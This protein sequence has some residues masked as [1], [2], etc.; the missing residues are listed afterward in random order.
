MILQA[1]K[2]QYEALAARGKIKEPGWSPEKVSYA[3][4]LRLDG[5]VINV[6][7]LMQPSEKSKKEAPIKILVPERVTRSSGVKANFLCDS[8]AYIFGWGAKGDPARALICFEACKKLHCDVLAGAESDAAR[9]VVNYFT[10]WAPQ[11]A[12]THPELHPY[13]ENLT[14]A[15][16]VF[17]FDG[18]YAHEDKAVRAAWREY[19]SNN[20]GKTMMRCL[21]TG[22]VAP[23]AILHSK[24]KGVQGAQSS[25]GALVSFNERAYESY[26]R[27]KGQ[28]LNAPV[29]EYAMFAYISALN[30]MLADYE[31][32]RRIGDMTV[33]HWGEKADPVMQDIYCKF[34][35]PQGED[36]DADIQIKDIMSRI[37]AGRHIEGVDIRKKFYV[38]G[39]APNAARLSVRLFWQGE[40]GY[41]LNNLCKHYNDIEIVKAP[42]EREY[43]SVSNLLYETVNQKSRDKAAAPQMAGDVFRAVLDGK[44]YPYT[45]YHATLRRLKAD[46]KVTRGRVAIIKAY[47]IRKNTLS[48]GE[49]L[50]VSLDKDNRNRGYLLGRLFASLES[51]QQA[52]NPGINATIKDRYFNAACATPQTAF[53]H[54][55]KLSSFHIKKLQREKIGLAINLEKEK[56]EILD[57]F[58]VKNTIF[59][60]RLSLEDQGMFIGGYYH[61]TQEKFRIIKEKK[62]QAESSNANADPGVGGDNDNDNV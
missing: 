47:L 19:A 3:L 58:D 60:A 8:A 30:C 12:E 6:I 15:N 4:N 62:D 53:V 27:E 21:V 14:A 57:L 35:D 55:M 23:I 56:A 45:L 59:P 24:I 29:S 39:I 41:M 54:L 17:W 38:L 22:E 33:V 46:R 42:Y 9:A 1:L 2:E 48:K 36:D 51:I 32:R 34:V 5:S 16:I 25:G 37:A 44:P 28:G 26:G 61:Q 10:E 18:S 40:F 52:V 20:D 13:L 43:L 7:P 49:C 50:S 31:H 11:D